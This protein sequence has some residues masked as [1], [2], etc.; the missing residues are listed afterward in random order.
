MEGKVY[1]SSLDIEQ[2]ILDCAVKME[3]VM[4]KSGHPEYDGSCPQ[5]L[6]EAHLL[7]VISCQ[8]PF[9]CNLQGQCGK[10]VRILI[11]LLEELAL[12][13]HSTCSQIASNGTVCA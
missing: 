1:V 3:K 12:Q 8:L 13:C 4:H 11:Y 2:V 9:Y 10:R 7:E 5:Q 6:K